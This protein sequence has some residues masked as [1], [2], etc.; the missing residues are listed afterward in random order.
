MKQTM[1][2][3]LRICLGMLLLCTI[4]AKAQNFSFSRDGL[5]YRYE[6][7]AE[8]RA[9]FLGLEDG[10][11]RSEVSIPDSVEYN[12]KKILV[13][14]NSYYLRK[15]PL[16]EEGWENITTLNLPRTI[17]RFDQRK[18]PFTKMPNL[19][20]ITVEDGHQEYCT[21]DNMLILKQGWMDP[22][23]YANPGQ[24]IFVS[25]REN[26]VLPEMVMS[27]M[28]SAFYNARQAKSLTLSPKFKRWSII[29][30]N[31]LTYLE[32]L[33]NISIDN[34]EELTTSADGKSL[35]SKNM[36]SLCYVVPTY[37]KEEY[38]V[39]HQVK[40]IIN[41]CFYKCDNIRR[42]ILSDGITNPYLNGKQLQL[43]N[44]EY[45][46]FGKKMGENIK[47]LMMLEKLRTF[48]FQ[49]E[50]LDLYFE[51]SVFL[52]VDDSNPYIS[53]EDTV[54]YTKDKSTLI[55]YPNW[56]RDKNC[57]IPEGVMYC[58]FGFP[59][60]PSYFFWDEREY[61]KL[62]IPSSLEILDYDGYS[63]VLIDTIYCHAQEPPIIRQ[64][65]GGD[66]TRTYSFVQK[67]DKW[68]EDESEL[69]GYSKPYTVMYVPKGT[70]SA[71]KESQWRLLD[72]REM[73]ETSITPPLKD[74]SQGEPLEFYSPL[75]I[76]TSKPTKGINIMRMGDGSV[77]KRL[78]R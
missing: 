20:N 75:G 50:C 25:P 9:N 51:S 39:P 28:D 11:S 57:V 7:Y 69:F 61:D 76:K 3:S 41:P 59:F 1:I 32:N 6:D 68:V 13:Q 43:R 49:T 16:W 34:G 44:L 72:I 14:I 66:V 33:E 30:R 67:H 70:L 22:V 60:F 37:D 4:S 17:N 47:E 12:G 78:Y 24:L 65:Y 26:I 77:R 10:Y 42:L 53:I 27:A 64:S 15:Q 52:D 45:L 62:F 63:A 58:P 40:K 55:Y 46:K 23:E 29:G 74:N 38:I 31:Y 36:D 5:L 73:D 35:F 56:K 8:G 21:I 48:Y 18:N 19:K 54:I 2:T 71:Y